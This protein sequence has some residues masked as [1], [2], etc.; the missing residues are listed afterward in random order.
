MTGSGELHDGKPIRGIVRGVV[1]DG[2][3]AARRQPTPAELHRLLLAGVEAR[4]HDGR[5]I[6]GL[7]PDLPGRRWVSRA[8]GPDDLALAHCELRPH[9]PELVS[10]GVLGHRSDDR[11]DSSIDV[12]ETL[13]VMLMIAERSR[14]DPA[15]QHQTR[16]AAVI[17]RETRAVPGAEAWS[18]CEI[19]IDGVAKTFQRQ[20]RGDDWIAFHDLGTECVY[21]HLE[22][23]DGYPVAIVTLTDVTPYM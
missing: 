23:P 8:G 18:P 6:F 17:E 14:N 1:L 12:Y 22:Q 21:L 19:E 4:L 9:S 2:M 20:D 16:D 7:A 11:P 3:D 5:P 13:G 15:F 10:I